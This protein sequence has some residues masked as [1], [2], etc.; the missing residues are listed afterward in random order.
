M[1][2]RAIKTRKLI[3][4]Q[5]D[6]WEVLEQSLPALEEETVVAISSKI[7]SIG[8][9]RCVAKHDVPDKDTLVISEATLYIDRK[10]TPHNFLHT[11]AR[12]LLAPTAGIDASNGADHYVLWPEDPARSAAD[13]WRRLR[14]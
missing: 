6:L 10:D 3:P 11:I 1:N 13:L 5:D 4:P 7:V 2:V 9:G 8:E 12:G 14:K